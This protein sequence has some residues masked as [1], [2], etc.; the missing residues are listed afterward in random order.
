LT[1]DTACTVHI[2]ANLKQNSKRFRSWIRVPVGIVW[3]KNEGRKSR[4]T[5]PLTFFPNCFCSLQLCQ[6]SPYWLHNR[7]HAHNSCLPNIFKLIILKTM[8]HFHSF[9]ISHKAI[10]LIWTANLIL[11]LLF[12]VFVGRAGKIS[13][14]YLIFICCS[15]DCTTILLAW[16]NLYLGSRTEML[17]L[18]VCAEQ[19]VLI[20]C[21]ICLGL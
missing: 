19:F 16:I 4:D 12:A 18:T 9:L 3:W 6:R 21:H 15:L 1:L 7:T 13:M 2:S 11:G 20:G 8:N 17:L 10:P 14:V 5:V